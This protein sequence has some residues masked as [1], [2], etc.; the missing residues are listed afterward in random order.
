MRC[1]RHIAW[2]SFWLLSIVAAGC[3]TKAT[4]REDALDP[5]AYLPSL[6]RVAATPTPTATP[7]PDATPARPEIRLTGIAIERFDAPCC[8]Q[9]SWW[10]VQVDRVQ[11]GPEV[12]NRQVV[13]VLFGSG[14]LA[15]L[16]R[17]DP[18]IQPGDRITAYGYYAH[19]DKDCAVDLIESRHYIQQASHLRIDPPQP[20]A[21]DVISLTVSGRWGS[22]CPAVI[23]SFGQVRGNVI[24]V[25]A[26]T[27][28]AENECNTVVTGWRYT[29]LLGPLPAGR[30]VVLAEVVDLNGGSFG[31]HDRLEFD[32]TRSPK[33]TR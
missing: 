29:E 32:V 28:D 13:K 11:E 5:R 19:I 27:T 15:R 1:T 4:A 21:T 8:D 12:C 24:Q 16:G 17:V 14:F 20:G 3:A 6:S 33:S 23:H 31:F 26:G 7:T 25:V 10:R 30:Y 9:L 22:S 18:S 2:V